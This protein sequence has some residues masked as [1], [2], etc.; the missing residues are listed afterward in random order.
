MEQ[1][2]FTVLVAVGIATALGEKSSS[3][4]SKNTVLHGGLHAEM[5]ARKQTS[6]MG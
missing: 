4:Y 3:I 6:R 5:G 2:I 1:S